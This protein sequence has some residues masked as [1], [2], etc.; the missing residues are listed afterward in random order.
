[1]HPASTRRLALAAGATA[2]AAAAAV[3]T[4][5]AAFA[6]G[7][8]VT[9][10]HSTI[11]VSSTA[12]QALS[13]AH[14]SINAVSP[15]TYSNH[16]I[17]LPISGGTANPPN[18]LIRY[19]GAF[20]LVKGSKTFSIHGIIENTSQHRVTALVNSHS[21]MTVFTLGDPQMGN[22]G[23]GEVMFGDYTVKWSSG[24]QT[25]FDN[26]LSTKAFTN[27]PSFGIGLTNVKFKS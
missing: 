14:I 27:H 26:H 10:G 3:A 6:A 4:T 17:K 25:Y 21:R 9:G 1:M 22:G 5:P 7:T 16:V 13:S 12:R 2:V 20:D 8:A 18:Y 24:A 11:T 19:H 15:A 23:P